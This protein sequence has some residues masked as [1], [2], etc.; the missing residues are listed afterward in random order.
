M[1]K[2][3]LYQFVL[4]KTL[5]RNY[6]YA[7]TIV[8]I[9]ISIITIIIIIIIIDRRNTDT[10]KQFG[11]SFTCHRINISIRV[12]VTSKTLIIF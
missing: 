9:S 2:L 3:C 1:W 6:I 7:T 8:I 5:R 12:K 11:L 4:G 10:Q